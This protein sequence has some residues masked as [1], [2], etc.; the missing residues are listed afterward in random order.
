MIRLFA[1]VAHYNK[2]SVE[3]TAV[4]QELLLK[5]SL[6]VQTTNVSIIKKSVYLDII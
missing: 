5:K 2:P 1:S 3:S 4:I 6:S